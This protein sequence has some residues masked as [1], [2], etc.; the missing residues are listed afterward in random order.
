MRSANRA[1]TPKNAAPT[2]GRFAA[3][4][5]QKTAPDAPSPS[6]RTAT[7]V[8]PNAHPTASSARSSIGTRAT[9]A[10]AE[11]PAR[12][13][14]TSSSSSGTSATTNASPPA[15]F[16]AKK[17]PSAATSAPRASRDDDRRRPNRRLRSLTVTAPARVHG[18]SVQ[19]ARAPSPLAWATAAPG[20]NTAAVLRAP[21]SAPS[22]APS[23][24]GTSHL[25]IAEETPPSSSSAVGAARPSNAHAK[26]TRFPPSAGERREPPNPA[27]NRVAGK[28]TGK[29]PPARAARVVT[30]GSAKFTTACSPDVTSAQSLPALSESATPA[31]PACREPPRASTAHSATSPAPP[32][33]NVS[34]CAA[35][36]SKR[37]SECPSGREQRWQEDPARCRDVACERWNASARARVSRRA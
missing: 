6:A 28:P 22:A 35:R 21:S 4:D 30:E 7:R 11:P 14:R 5:A 1:P 10:D 25:C 2:T 36:A 32:E 9:R 37:H 29:P 15:S 17:D 8:V 20:G 13:P 16:G 19:A 18:T 34:A 26:G 24:G 27:P 31:K 23:D 12:D 3:G 33:G